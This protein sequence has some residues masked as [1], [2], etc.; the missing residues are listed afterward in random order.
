[1]KRRIA[2][3]DG[4]DPIDVAIGAR[5]RVQRLCLGISQGDLAQALGITFQQVQRYERGTNRLSAS[6]LVKASAKLRT[7]VAALVGEAG[8]PDSAVLSQLA[9]PRAAEMLAAY[10]QISDSDVRRSLL[11]LAASLVPPR[12][13]AR[14]GRD[15]RSPH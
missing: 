8:S 3:I 7:T 13:A 14:A 15:D 11:E 6:M 5:L 1:M 9:A 2:S 12:A 4:P 10:A